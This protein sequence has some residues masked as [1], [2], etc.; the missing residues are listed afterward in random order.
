M[1]KEQD[2]KPR[3]NSRSASPLTTA[4][5]SANLR[6]VDLARLVGVSTN[7]IS[8]IETG[9]RRPTPDVARAIALVFGLTIAELF[10]LEAPTDAPAEKDAD[11]TGR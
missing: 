3:A 10:G 5:L 8:A 11:E 4:R 7:L 9:T 6:Q 1:R 2:A